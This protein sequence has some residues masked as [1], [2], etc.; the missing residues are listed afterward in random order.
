MRIEANLF[1]VKEKQALPGATYNAMLSAPKMEK[2]KESGREMLVFEAKIIDPIGPDF[3]DRLRH[4]IVKHD[5]LGW[6]VFGMKE[7]ADACNLRYDPTGFDTDDFEGKQ[8]K[9]VVEQEI[10]QDKM[11]NKIVHFLKS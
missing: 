8:C 5:T 6:A 7:I 3:W 2:A 1:E 11:Q 10:Y 4:R 9:V